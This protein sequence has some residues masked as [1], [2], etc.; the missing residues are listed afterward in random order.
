MGQAVTTFDFVRAA[1]D[2]APCGAV[3]ASTTSTGTIDYINREFTALTGYTID[4][5]PTI[6]DWVERAYPDPEYRAFVVGNWERDVTE[7]GRDVVYRVRT[8]SGADKELLMRAGLLPGE[9]M[10]VTMLDVS[11]HLTYQCDLRESEARYRAVIDSMSSGLVVHSQGRIVFANQAAVDLARASSREELIGRSVLSFVHPD[12]LPVV[13]ARIKALYKKEISPA[14]WIEEKWVRL[15]GE[16]F[17]VEVSASQVDWK[18]EPASQVVFND[19]T[20]R[21][22]MEQERRTFEARVQ[23]V[24]KMESL[25][26]LAGGVAHDFNNLLVGILG[27]ADLALTELPPESP[28]RGYI[29]GIE[30]AS[31]RAADLARQM[32][33]YSGKG[34]FI[35]ERLD[36]N[37]L[38]AEITHLLEASISKKAVLKTVLREDLPVIEGDPTQIRQVM[39]NLV[40]NASEALKTG[41]GSITLSTGVME[42]DA[43]YLKPLVVNDEVR[44]GTYA[45][46]E[47]SD[48]G[49]GMD[50]ETVQKIFD[51][52]FTTKFTGR[53][54]GLAAVQGIVKGH[55]GAIKVYSEPGTGTTVKVL[56]PMADPGRSHV[57]TP[58]PTATKAARERTILLVDDEETVRTVGMHMLRRAGYHV[59]TAEDGRA[60]IE[61]FSAH[62]DEIE[63]VV[64]DLSMPHMDGEETFRE[65][66][67]IRPDVKVL[68]SSGYIE[69][70]A[71]NRFS[72]KKLAGFIQKPYRSTA[73]EEALGKILG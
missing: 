53:G 26:V 73:L 16:S 27:N 42:C 55:R 8:K 63:C 71:V 2:N 45:Y 6:P 70:D 44:A 11:P 47:V 12:S 18:G 62:A 58:P 20:E 60:A 40:T 68:L 41:S 72:G 9:L 49:I 50:S 3:V 31:R 51:P 35:V 29:E 38:I 4:D 28:V 57:T 10:V 17:D 52:F 23:Y 48:T 59:L 15:D 21:K 37:R 34:R 7:T 25:G 69:Q 19:I 56:F 36:L 33:A 46:L 14:P 24:Q 64:L 1:L 30:R 39:M 5:V 32:L 66:R 22:R 43:D 54:L 61:M 13:H 65:L 67:R